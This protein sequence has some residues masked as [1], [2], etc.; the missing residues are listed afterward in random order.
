MR[1]RGKPADDGQQVVEV[2]GNPAGRV[3]DGVQ[4]L[5]MA[6]LSLQVGLALLAAVAVE[7]DAGGAGEQVQRVHLEGPVV[8]AAIGNRQAAQEFLPD[9][10]R[11]PGEPDHAR[12]GHFL[13]FRVRCGVVADL[14][15]AASQ[16]GAVAGIR[17]ARARRH[18]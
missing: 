10:H 9:R 2:V 11:H 17:P 12:V 1:Q 16:Q 15:H 5:A 8:V 18:G 13:P 3:A 14:G 7:H 6:Q 4:L